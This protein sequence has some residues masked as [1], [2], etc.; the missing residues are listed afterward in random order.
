MDMLA[1]LIQSKI[2][3]RKKKT[4]IVFIFLKLMFESSLSKNS[5]ADMRL[6]IN[7][8]AIVAALPSDPITPTA[9]K[10]CS[11]HTGAWFS[12]F[13]LGKSFSVFPPLVGAP[14]VPLRVRCVASTMRSK[15]D[16]FLACV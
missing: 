14:V 6:N 1:E 13:R 2:N 3:F 15:Y 9:S 12:I 10:S 7:P 11:T 8:A 4:N 5:W 16:S